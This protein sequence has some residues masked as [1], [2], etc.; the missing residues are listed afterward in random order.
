MTKEQIQS[1]ALTRA[2]FNTSMANF[3]PIIAGFIEKGISPDDIKPR[4]N[5]FTFEA[6]RALGRTVKR[7]EHGVKIHTFVPMEVKDRG[8]ADNAAA[9][10]LNKAKV[11]SRPRTTTVF[12]ISQTKP[13]D[14]TQ[15]LFN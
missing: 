5:V 3:M 14:E 2:K 8:Q 11:I 7:G 4:E 6:W 12:H 9:G 15:A 1:S 13:L 10:D